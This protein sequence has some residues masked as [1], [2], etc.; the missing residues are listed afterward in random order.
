MGANALEIR[1]VCGAL[2]A[3]VR[4]LDL[5]R[6]LG[7]REFDELHAALLQHRV[8]FLRDQEIGDEQQLALARRFGSPTIYPALRALGVERPLEFIEDTEQSPPKADGWHTDIT[9][10][11]NP[12]R[13]GILHARVIPEYGGDTIWVNLELA[14]RQLS[15]RMQRMLEGLVVHH[16]VDENFHRNVAAILG[17]E[18]LERVRAHVAGGADHP[19]VIRHPLTGEKLLYVA[20]YW[21]KHVCELSEDESRTLLDFLMR[22][23]T[24]PGLQVRWRWRRN[25]VA[26]WDERATL[27][28]ALGDH[29][30]PHRLMRRCTVD[31]PAHPPAARVED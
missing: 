22:H 1:R 15:P 7:E 5:R 10:V 24:Q 31:D 17:P 27:H 9:W 23:V 2:G 14:W 12:P 20:G 8:V 3:E 29:Y 21:M 16:D 11:A 28:R 18:K 25:D 30:P 19:L 6:P 4:G 13:Y 26:I